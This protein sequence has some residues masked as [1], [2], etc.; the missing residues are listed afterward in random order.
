[1]GQSTTV[2]TAFTAV[3]IIAG[4]SILVTSTVSSFGVISRGIDS[5]VSQNEAMLNEDME[6][7]SWRLLDSQTLRANVTNTG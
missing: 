3:M 6:F 2:A 1:M 5:M 7:V 4:V